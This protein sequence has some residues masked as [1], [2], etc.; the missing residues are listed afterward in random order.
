MNLDNQK[1]MLSYHKKFSAID[2]FRAMDQKGLGY[3]TVDSFEKYFANDDDFQEN[4]FL[5]LIQYWS[6]SNQDRL[7]C[8]DL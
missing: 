2:L 4:N 7:S 8:I 3:L 5:D 1:K 6:G